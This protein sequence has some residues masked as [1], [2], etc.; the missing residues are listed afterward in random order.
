MAAEG[1]RMQGDFALFGLQEP[2]FRLS[3]EDF[4]ARS[5]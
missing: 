2:H 1:S 5:G 3:E 4:A